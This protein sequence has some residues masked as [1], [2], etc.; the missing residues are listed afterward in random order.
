M[1]FSG[2][3]A[4]GGGG[5]VAARSFEQVGM[6][7]QQL[8]Q[9]QRQPSWTGAGRGSFVG[10][11]TSSL[12]RRCDMCQNE[13]KKKVLDCRRMD[14]MRVSQALKNI[15]LGFPTCDD[16]ARHSASQTQKL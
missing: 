10:S 6:H 5:G 8:H 12:E 9:Q 11:A 14:E 7:Q 4:R 2:G 3:D 15:T 1:V 13:K 16:N